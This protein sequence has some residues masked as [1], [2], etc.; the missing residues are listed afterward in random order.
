MDPSLEKKLSEYPE[1]VFAVMV[2]FSSMIC[3]DTFLVDGISLAAME[4]RVQELVANGQA[5]EAKK[6]YQKIREAREAYYFQCIHNFT[7]QFKAYG[8][9]IYHE[10]WGYT[11]DGCIFYTFA[12]KEQIENLQAQ[13]HQAFY[14]RIAV[15]YK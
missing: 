6:L 4:A 14:L 12:T 2:D 10:K 9:G 8:L 3:K 11:L 13:P 5:E 15:R 7:P 1:G